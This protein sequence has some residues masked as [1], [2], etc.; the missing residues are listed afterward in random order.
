MT[1][2]LRM[3]G[4]R[5]KARDGKTHIF[6]PRRL[7]TAVRAVYF[8]RQLEQ[9]T[10]VLPLHRAAHRQMA[11]RKPVCRDTGSKEMQITCRKAA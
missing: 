5:R 8:S 9:R 6:L 3:P 7:K 10:L 2:F 1:C 4:K 11:G